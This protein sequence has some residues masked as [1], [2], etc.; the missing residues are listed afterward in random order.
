M[1]EEKNKTYSPMKTLKRLFKIS[2]AYLPWYVLLCI[3]ASLRSVVAL[4]DTEVFRRMI[5]GA[6][7]GNMSMVKIGIIM[8]LIALIV[9]QTLDFV[10]DYFGEILNFSSTRALQS[11]ILNKLTKIQMSKYEGYHSGDLIDRLDNCANEAQTGMNSNT[12]MIFE[13][14]LVIILS[15]AYLIVLNFRLM[16]GTLIFILLLPIIIN[17]LAKVMRGFYDKRQKLRVEKDSFVQDSFQGGEIVR[18]F[19]LSSRLGITYLAKYN[20]FFRL[21]KKLLFFESI[22][23]T[24]HWIIIFGGDLFILGYGGYLASKGIMGVGSVLAFLL[25]FEKTMQPI[26]EISIIWPKFQQ[27]ISS[28]NRVFE[29]LDLPEENASNEDAHSHM[30]VDDA[31]DNSNAEININNVSF[32]YN[33]ETQVLKGLNFSCEEG[34]VTALVGPSGGGKSTIL[35]MLIRLYEPSSGEIT[36]GNKAL[37]SMK[38]QVWRKSLAYVSQEPLLFS[39]TILENIKYGNENVTYEE[40]EQAAKCANIH[41]AILATAQGYESKI[42]EQGIRF[43]GGERQ[44]ISIA[45]AML[46]DP[47]LLILDEPTSALDSENERLIQEALDILMERRTT[48]IV[49]HRLSTIQ[50]ADKIVFIEEGTV[51]EEG[52][53]NELMDLKGK[54]YNMHE[55]IKQ[56]AELGLGENNEK[57]VAV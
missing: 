30:R 10:I 43:S 9:G 25:M 47:K 50:N 24:T 34:K 15:M 40:V 12:R 1:S 49:A 55:K 22:M 5:N 27:A 28:A 6:T 4:V 57:E 23:N 14:S 45:R 11:K 38:L 41:D 54:Y 52:T 21:V 37:S 42:G 29:I 19:S 7:E 16:I 17:P 18:S 46:R 2:K 39:G 31:G 51:Q 20:S 8:G 35:K 13:K 44:R 56:T 26:S 3:A 36:C 53:H 33:E 32:G 48:V